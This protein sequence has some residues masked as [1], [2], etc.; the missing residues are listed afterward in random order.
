MRFLRKYLFGN[1]LL[2]LLALS[3]SFLL[4]TT[5]TSEPFSEIGIQVPLEFID[6]PPRLEISGDVPTAVHVRIRGRSALLRRLVPADLNLRLDMKD[7]KPGE[8]LIHLTPDMVGSPYG[9][10]IV[11]I[12][13]PELHVTLVP[14]HEPAP[15]SR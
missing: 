13:P 15:A 12:S 7:D 4:W 8:A 9:A 14:R 6:I 5:Y 3:I 1:A 10:N 11:Q 2:K